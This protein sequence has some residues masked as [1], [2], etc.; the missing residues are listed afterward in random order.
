MKKDANH[1]IGFINASRPER[2]SYPQGVH[3][4]REVRENSARKVKEGRI[5]RQNRAI[6]KI[7]EANNVQ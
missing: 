7:M 4:L 3:I 6:K 1:G 5:P 2:K